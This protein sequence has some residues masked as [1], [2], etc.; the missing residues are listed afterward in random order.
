MTRTEGGESNPIPCAEFTPQPT[1][2]EVA[3]RLKAPVLKAVSA[4][5]PKP[6][7]IDRTYC[8]PMA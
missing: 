6:F 4:P 7:Q 1:N 5:S 2:G 3:E 8:Q